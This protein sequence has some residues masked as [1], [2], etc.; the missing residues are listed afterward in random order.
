MFCESVSRNLVGVDEILYTPC[1][2]TMHSTEGRRAGAG[3]GERRVVSQVSCQ[4]HFYINSYFSMCMV[5]L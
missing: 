1:S 2:L 3:R 4:I 5:N